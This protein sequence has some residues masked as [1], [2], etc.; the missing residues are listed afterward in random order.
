MR[1]VIV[2][3]NGEAQVG[4]STLARNTLAELDH[5]SSPFGTLNPV[6]YSL[7]EP[8]KQFSKLFGQ[9]LNPTVPFLTYEEFK[10]T[11]L[12][13]DADVTGRSVILEMGLMARRLHPDVLMYA[14]ADKMMSNQ[15]RNI[16]IIENWGFPGELDFFTKPIFYS[17]YSQIAVNATVVTVHVDERATRRYEHNE[18]FD[19]DSRFCL[20]ASAQWLNPTPAQLAKEIYGFAA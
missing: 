19:N 13:P 8:L 12:I 9:M 17:R 10:R 15:D 20:R 14:L 16:W 6:V 18:Q 7:V 3:I 2:L 1:T 4:K 5:L 11:T